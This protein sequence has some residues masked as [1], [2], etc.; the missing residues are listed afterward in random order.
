MKNIKE[1]F[2]G[3]QERKKNNSKEFQ[4]GEK[5]QREDRKKIQRKVKNEK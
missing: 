5:I 3:I 1:K 4:S 2:I